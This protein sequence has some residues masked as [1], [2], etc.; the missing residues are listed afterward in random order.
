MAVSK[1]LRYEVL[2]RDGYACR[3]CGT[4]APD[5]ALAIDHVIPVSLGGADA[6]EN[7]VAACVDCNTGKA[8]SNP[9][10]DFVADVRADAIRWAQAMYFVMREQQAQLDQLLT[11]VDLVD[12]MWQRWRLPGGQPLPRPEDWR[13]SVSTMRDQFVNES[14]WRYAIDWA[15]GT[16]RVPAASKWRY[17]CGILWKRIRERVDSAQSVAAAIDAEG[18]VLDMEALV[19]DEAE[20]AARADGITDPPEVS[21]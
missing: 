5:A 8:A 1:R 10:A 4:V 20:T 16:V 11:Y 9:D 18:L 17:T 2:R 13:Q 12:G 15:M 21:P 6:A 19:E 14:E 3:Y 7:L